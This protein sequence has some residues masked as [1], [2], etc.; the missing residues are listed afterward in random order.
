MLLRRSSFEGVPNATRIGIN[1]FLLGLIFR[2]D[3]ARGE[4]ADVYL[5]DHSYR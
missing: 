5:D 4:A 3:G 2:W 1:D